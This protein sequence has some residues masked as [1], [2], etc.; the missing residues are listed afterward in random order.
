M[1]IEDAAPARLDLGFLLSRLR[2][3]L[4]LFALVTLACTALGIVIALALPTLYRAEALLVVESEQI[5]DE[6]AQSTV[7]TNPSE[8]LQIVA[9]RVVSREVLIRLSDRLGIPAAEGRDAAAPQTSTALVE[10]LRRRI[11]IEPLRDARTRPSDADALLVRVAFDSPRPDVAVAVANEIVT[12][13][14][15]ED[16]ATRLQIARQT[17]QFFQQEVT[18][19][20]GA[21]QAQSTEIQR[22]KEENIAALPE[23]QVFRREDLARIEAR[24]VQ[25][26]RDRRV[27]LDQIDRID[28]L[29]SGATI[30]REEGTSAVEG[31]GGGAQVTTRDVRRGELVTELG[32]LEEEAEQLAAQAAALEATLA[33]A[34]R[35]GIRLEVLERD[36]ENIRGQYDLAIS[37]LARAEIGEMIESLA[38]GRRISVIEQAVRPDR[39]FSPNRP[40]IA[41][42]SLA[43][44]LALATG[45]LIALEM[46]RS[47]IRRPEDITALVG[48]R[49]VMTLPVIRSRQDR[50][51]LWGAWILALGGLALILALA[52]QNR[53]ELAGH[54]GRVLETARSLLPAAMTGGR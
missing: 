36:Y 43:A 6:L 16:A 3:W 4:W 31:G 19:L 49:M 21:L 41:A 11:V 8:Q 24:R 53:A 48:D 52:L 9:R 2:R 34:P 47:V 44:G 29:T 15:E 50:L 40:R 20:S 32:Y 14:L 12:L 23:S 39:P 37:N 26:D 25:L 28:R 35:V 54:L 18:R 45:L 17:Q 22:F 13:I 51:R 10:D 1:L 5:P 7:Q 27:L 38:K 33:E 30:P 46:F 42:I